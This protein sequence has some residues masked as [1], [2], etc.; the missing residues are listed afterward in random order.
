VPLASGR[1]L[2][3]AGA[4]PVRSSTEERLPRHDRLF[5]RLLATF[6]PDFL[7]LF[8]PALAR[9]IEPGSLRLLDKE[10]SDDLARGP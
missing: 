1:Q 7:D 9:Q 2:L 5:R 3:P 10:T 8:A 4:L 6:F